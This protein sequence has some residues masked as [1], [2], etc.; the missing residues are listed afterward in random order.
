MPIQRALF[1]LITIELSINCANK[2]SAGPSVGPSA[3]PSVGPSGGPSAG[4]SGGPSAGPADQ[5]A[6]VMKYFSHYKHRQRIT[7]VRKGERISETDEIVCFLAQVSCNT[8]HTEY[9]MNWKF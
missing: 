4:P 6:S 9:E 3:G 1:Q 8:K 5:G 7:I 2:Y